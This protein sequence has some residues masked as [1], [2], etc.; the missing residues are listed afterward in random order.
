MLYCKCNN[1][2]PWIE[3]WQPILLNGVE[4]CYFTCFFW[5]HRNNIH[6]WWF[7][8]LKPWKSFLRNHQVFSFF[9]FFLWTQRSCVYQSSIFIVI[10]FLAISIC[11]M[12]NPWCTSLGCFVC[13][14]EL[15]CVY[16]CWHVL[17]NTEKA[18]GSQAM[19]NII[20]LSSNSLIF[21]LLLF[22]CHRPYNSIK[23]VHSLVWPGQTR[24]PMIDR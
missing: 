7:Y 9:F 8:E 11:K 6:T 20:F 16:W 22:S 10:N 5:I 24:G 15:L 18:K 3:F 14:A 13:N 19:Q 12:Q 2:G 4:D 23:K 21:L 1:N 17:S